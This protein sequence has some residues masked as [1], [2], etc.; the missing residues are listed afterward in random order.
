LGQN[1]HYSSDDGNG[2]DDSDDGDGGDDSN[3]GDSGDD[4]DNGDSGDG[5]DVRIFTVTSPLCMQILPEYLTK[6]TQIVYL[7][8]G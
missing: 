7:D 3:D 4:S 2:G 8:F 1:F 6:T 5:G